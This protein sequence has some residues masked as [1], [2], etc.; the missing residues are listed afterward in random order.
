MRLDGRMPGLERR[1][2]RNS[3]AKN[4][5]TESRLKPVV[6]DYPRPLYTNKKNPVELRASLLRQRRSF[7]PGIFSGRPGPGQTQPGQPPLRN[8][9]TERWQSGR[10][11]LTRN[12]AYGIP[13][14]WVRIPPSP[15]SMPRP[16]HHG[17]AFLFGSSNPVASQIIAW[18]PQTSTSLMGLTLTQFL[19]PI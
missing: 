18:H 15:P 9:A 14:P 11:Y 8:P 2:C 16:T 19:V 12:Q 6:G 10:M 5:A 1:A 17:L 3:G 7:R 13:V 4:P